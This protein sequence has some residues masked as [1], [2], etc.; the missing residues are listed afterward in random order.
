LGWPIAAAG[1]IKSAKDNRSDRMLMVFPYEG[2]MELSA[3]SR[4]HIAS[5]RAFS[6]S[7]RDKNHRLFLPLFAEPIGR[8]F[9]APAP[10]L[11]LPAARG[12]GRKRFRLYLGCRHTSITVSD[13]ATATDAD[14]VA[15]NDQGWRQL[16][17]FEFIGG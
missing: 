6:A 2:F 8:T 17:A 9:R 14:R 3:E 5:R 11:T 16:P 4:D 15:R 1:A 12:R 7:V 10:A 13:W